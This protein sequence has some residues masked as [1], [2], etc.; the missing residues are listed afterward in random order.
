MNC[1]ISCIFISLF[2]PISIKDCSQVLHHMIFSAQ[3]PGAQG[4]V[5][6]RKLTPRWG[7]VKD[8]KRN[9]LSGDMVKIP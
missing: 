4:R 7:S 2:R 8:S 6:F 1:D 3:H 5:R 9:G